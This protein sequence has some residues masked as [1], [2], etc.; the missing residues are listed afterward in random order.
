L[1]AEEKLACGISDDLIRLSIGLEEIDDILW[2]LDRAL[3]RAA[4]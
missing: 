4:Q 2:D 1:T 3:G